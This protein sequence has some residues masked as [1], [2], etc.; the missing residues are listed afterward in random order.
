MTIAGLDIGTT[1]CKVSVYR[2]DGEHIGTEYR[3]YDANNRADEIDAAQILRAVEQVIT[4]MTLK[5]R[6]DVLGVTSFGETFVLLDKNDNILLP[7]MLYSDTR[8]EMQADMLNC[9]RTEQI[10]G[11]KSSYTFSLPKIAWVRQNLPDIFE[12]VNRIMLMQDF[13]VY[14]L[15]GSAQIDYTMAARTMGFNITSL[16]WDKTLLEAVGIKKEMFSMPVPSGTPAGRSNRFGLDNALI[17]NGCHDQIASLLGAGITEP[18]FAADGIGT[19]ECITPVF[20]GVPKKTEFYS[21]GYAAIPFIR[22]NQYA[23]YGYNFSGGATLKWYKNNFYRVSYAE[24][25]ELVDPS[26]PSKLLVLPYFGGAA[27]PYMDGNA[28]GAIIGLDFDTTRERLYQ[29]ML[30]GTTYEMLLNAEK[31][32]QCGIS[33]SA[34]TA[35]GGGSKSSKW[36][37]LKA[38]IMNMPIYTILADE[39]GAAGT[40]ILAGK[41]AGIYKSLDEA[42][43]VFVRPGKTYEPDMSAVPRFRDYYERY[44]NMYLHIREI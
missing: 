3:E 7:S 16:C 9:S 31:L 34:L 41:A 30:E 11:T 40:V 38:N 22:E 43:S 19:V 20:N 35:T 18:G 2:E 29:A 14:A 32:K 27:T 37:Q 17:V 33:F 10:T 21:S 13:V 26:E 36:L 6:I 28:K 23:T 24:A 12:K 15:T 44:L 5:C 1:G 4:A 8:G 25:D 39:V 42:K